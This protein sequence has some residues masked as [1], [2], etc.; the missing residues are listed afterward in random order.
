M[1]HTLSYWFTPSFHDQVDSSE[2]G[3]DR[4]ACAH[5]LLLAIKSIAHAPG[6]L[7]AERLS[8]AQPTPTGIVSCGQGRLGVSARTRHSVDCFTYLVCIQA[9]GSAIIVHADWCGMG[10]M[11]AS[12][13]MHHTLHFINILFA[14]IVTYMLSMQTCLTKQEGVSART[15]HF[16]YA[17]MMWAMTYRHIIQLS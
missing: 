9:K 8:I 15:R 3:I 13:E 5:S 11:G 7:I 6:T 12:T 4:I 10:K 2:S 1:C 17:K 14:M 16:Y